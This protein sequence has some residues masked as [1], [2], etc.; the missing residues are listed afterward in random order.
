MHGVAPLLILCLLAGDAGAR[1][2]ARADTKTQAQR[3][4]DLTILSI[5][6][7]ND[8]HGH[9][10]SLPWLSA[11]VA[12]LRRSRT[13]DKGAVL[14]LD[15]GDMFQGTLPSNLGE[16]AIVVRAYNTL[17]YTA[18]AIGNHE[19]DFGPEGPAATIDEESDGDPRGA[20]RARAREARFPFL[21]A[22][23][24]AAD[25]GPPPAWANV[26][27]SM[28]V[29]AAQLKIGI[30]GV[31][32]PGTPRATLPANLRGLDVTPLPA[33]IEA[34][35]RKLRKA[36]A[37][38]VIVVAHEGGKCLRFDEPDDLSSCRGSDEIFAVARALPAHLVDVIVAGH[39]H[40]GIA[41]RVAGIAIVESFANG[42]AFGRVDLT[43]DRR[44]K[45]VVASTIFSPR[46]LC[47][48]DRLP[49]WPPSTESCRP[50]LYE[51]APVIADT[52]M[53]KLL[54][55]AFGV[56]EARLSDPLGVTVSAPVWRTRQEESP[57]GNLFADLMLAA[58][59]ED[60]VALTNGGG[61]RAD[62]PAGPLTYGRLFEAYPFDNRFARMT[63]SGADLA[64]AVARNLEQP[65][66]VVSLSGVRA[67][68]RCR[69]GALTVDLLRDDGRRVDPDEQLS[70]VSSD[71][72][73]TGGDD[74]FP[75]GK[76]EI[77]GGP[78]IREAMAEQLRKRTGALSG[79]D[80]KLFNRARRRLDYPGPRPVR[81][82]P[83]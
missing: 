19:F 54:A 55:P 9:I 11:H 7:T 71:F 6:G 44:A 23:I 22:N 16:G 25:G 64:D 37:S 5:V 60:D 32:T 53:T 75:D 38:I 68:A 1:V 41:H 59:P 3:R 79:D 14:L 66:G 52:G 35:A 73:L 82:D 43:Y 26:H 48:F 31:T 8:L 18:A 46:Y 45:K 39:T 51:G 12:N 63:I 76:S 81:C 74:L 28:L 40:E 34:E 78:T 77:L 56:A 58:Q 30:V 49:T 13:R 67:T 36:G 57:L 72:I 10:E 15:A 17:G 69:D 24:Q 47:G 70:L 27:P 80:P 4:A 83:P 20:L 2:D 21:A 42:R 33:V 50:D 61:L 29:T 65:G 62:L